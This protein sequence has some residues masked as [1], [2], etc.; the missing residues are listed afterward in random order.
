[1]VWASDGSG[2][3]VIVVG[4]AERIMRLHD[5]TVSGRRVLP[6]EAR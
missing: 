2:W 1:V 5:R 4:A 3:S 6:A